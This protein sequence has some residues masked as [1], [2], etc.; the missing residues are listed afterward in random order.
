M[1]RVALL[2]MMFVMIGAAC[3]EAKPTILRTP[4]G[5]VQPQAVVDAKGVVH[6][7]YLKGKDTES[8]VF[9]VRKE[10]GKDRFSEPIRVNSVPGSAVAMGTIRGAHIALG[11]NGRVHVAWNG[12]GK[13]TPKSFNNTSPMCYA[14]LDDSGKAFERQRNLMTQSFNLDGGGT[15]AADDQGNVYVAWHAAKVGEANG[16]ASRKVWVAISTDDGKTFAKETVAS[17]EPTGACGCCGMKGF[18][19]SKG[20]LHLLYRSASGGSRD[21][22]KLTS[23]DQGKSFSGALVQR[24]KAES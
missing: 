17:T 9:Y 4:N 16:E 19:D 6:L 8:D 21:I 2:S 3:A 7:V 1:R 5:G 13:A 22:Y 11:K 20:T 18:A 10:P 12:S 24:W 14:R 23:K 15:V